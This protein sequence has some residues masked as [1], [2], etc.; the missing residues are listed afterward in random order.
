ML[1]GQGDQYLSANEKRQKRRAVQK[2]NNSVRIISLPQSRKDGTHVNSL[3][4]LDLLCMQ[5][6]RPHNQ[7]VS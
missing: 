7:R 6:E 2:L 4:C 3:Y 5:K 1:Q